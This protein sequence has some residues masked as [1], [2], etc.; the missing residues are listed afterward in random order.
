MYLSKFCPY[1]IAP[2]ILVGTCAVLSAQAD[3]TGNQQD[4]AAYEGIVWSGLFLGSD[5]DISGHGREVRDELGD[6]IERF[7]KV[8][9]L[10]F[11]HYRLLGEHAQKL[12]K[13]FDSWIVPSEEIFLKLDSRGPVESGGVQ[14]AVQL[15]HNKA[16]LVK[17]DVILKNGRPLLIRGPQWGDG[18]ILISLWLDR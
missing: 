15:W 11:S 7:Q 4:E 12:Y 18:Y 8:D 5:E 9:S 2:L 13:E 1:A 17:A 14:L 6:V 3:E 10:R 16:V